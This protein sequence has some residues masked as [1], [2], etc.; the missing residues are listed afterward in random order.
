MRK[1]YYAVP[2][3]FR[4][5]LILAVFRR[6]FVKNFL[7]ILQNSPENT[8]TRVSF[9]TKLQTL[10]TNSG[11]DVF[12]WILPNFLRTPFY[13]EHIRW[14]LLDIVQI[15]QGL[16]GVLSDLR[17]F[18]VTESFSKMMKNAFHFTLKA[19]F[20]LKIFNFLSWLLGHLGWMVWLET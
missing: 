17:K 6:C 19:F 10:V 20:I 14:L 13:I 15:Y 16:K 12:L 3:D 1:G 5:K 18:F 8:C 7:E 11:T 9:L 2:R 4:K